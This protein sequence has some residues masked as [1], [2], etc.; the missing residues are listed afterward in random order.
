MFEDWLLRGRRLEMVFLDEER[1]CR[2][3]VG[4]R[5]GLLVVLYG[6]WL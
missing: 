2:W 4:W 6:V 1:V 3:M 5:L